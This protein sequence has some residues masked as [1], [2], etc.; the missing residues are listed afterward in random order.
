MGGPGSGTWYR[1]NKRTTLD[2]VQRLD[3]RWLHRSGYLTAYPHR[4][5]WHQGKHQAGAISLSLQPEGLVLEYS[6]RTSGEDWEPVR[7]VI[8]LDWTL[9]YGGGKRPWF[10]CPG[11]QRRVA[12]FCSR[13]KWFLCRHCYRLPYASQC[14]APID[15]TYRRVRKIRTRLG[16]SH[17]LHIPVL[18]WQ[19][20][21]GMHWK[22]WERLCRQE[23][24]AH[25]VVLE[26]M[27]LG[28]ERLLQR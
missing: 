18:P 23:R 27:G 4:V 7:E 21:K 8:T 13:G 2:Q 28:L 17:N 19:K 16:A 14:E 10:L 20:P 5:T 3:I 9:C 24:D 1:W 12:I 25:T 11:C 22:T 15:R 26:Y 6:Y